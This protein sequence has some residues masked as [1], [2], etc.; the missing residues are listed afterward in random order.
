MMS[1]SIY[2]GQLYNILII[3]NRINTV[4]KPWID[5]SIRLT[6]NYQRSPIYEE[7]VKIEKILKEYSTKK[8]LHGTS[9][10]LRTTIIAKFSNTPVPFNCSL[11]II[12]YDDWFVYIFRSTLQTLDNL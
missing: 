5:L 2:L 10:L 4:V 1:L 11:L 8:T 9:L 7:L 6:S 12:N 3:Y